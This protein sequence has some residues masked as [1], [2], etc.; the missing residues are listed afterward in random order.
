MSRMATFATQDVLDTAAIETYGAGDFNAAEV[1]NAACHLLSRREGDL[2]FGAVAW[3]I[4]PDDLCGRCVIELKARVVL[5]HKRSYGLYVIHFD[6]VPALLMIGL[7][8]AESDSGDF[9]VLDVDRTTA[10]LCYLVDIRTKKEAVRFVASLNTEE[11]PVPDTTLSHQSLTL[12]EDRRE[13][14]RW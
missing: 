11:L 10:L 5:D 4:F 9:V 14:W 8:R 7:G 6:G 1:L 2:D 13:R 12:G 3:S